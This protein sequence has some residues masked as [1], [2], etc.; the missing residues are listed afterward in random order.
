M[1]AVETIEIRQ[2]TVEA[3]MLFHKYSLLGFSFTLILFTVLYYNHIF[4]NLHSKIPFTSSYLTVAVSF[5]FFKVTDPKLI[6]W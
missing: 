6:I 1:L 3:L 4:K 2:Y 5:N